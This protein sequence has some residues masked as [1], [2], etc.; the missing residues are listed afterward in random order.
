MIRDES[1]AVCASA[2]ATITAV[3][4][5]NNENAAAHAGNTYLQRYASMLP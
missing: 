1:E 5:S 4:S 2:T 3:T